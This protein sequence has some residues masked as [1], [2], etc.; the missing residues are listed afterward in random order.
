MAGFSPAEWAVNHMRALQEK[1]FT[2]DDIERASASLAQSIMA[3]RNTRWNVRMCQACESFAGCSVKALGYGSLN[4][5]LMIVNERAS[6]DD[7]LWGQSLVGT[8]G[9]LLALMLDKL[10]V[11]MSMVYVTSLIKCY[12]DGITA[13]VDEAENCVVHLAQEIDAIKPAVVLTFGQLVP[14]ILF[15]NPDFRLT[16]PPRNREDRQRYVDENWRQYSRFLLRPSYSL[17]SI[18][19][20]EGE[21]QMLAKQTIWLDLRA[22][23][24]KAQELRPEYSYRVIRDYSLAPAAS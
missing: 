23:L 4:S 6:A 20:T 14:S 18:L 22:A 19:E 24:T 5:P 16:S 17:R 8:E 7:I 2:F 21:R 15:G 13:G 3:N 11:D 12:K 9:F 1:G 10:G